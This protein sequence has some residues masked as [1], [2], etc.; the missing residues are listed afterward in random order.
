MTAATANQKELVRILYLEHG[1]KRAAELSGVNYDRVRQ[2]AHRYQ[3]KQGLSQNV[4]KQVAE[5]VTDELAENERETRLSLS[6]Y[7]RRAAKDSEQATLKDAPYVKAA[8]QVAGIT[9]KW[10]DQDGKAQ[11][12]TLNVLNLNSLE[13]RQEAEADTLDA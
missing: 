12:F 1:H 9:H 8:A 7:A 6:R 2:W 5:R 3:W 4:T 11:H 13:V 10:N